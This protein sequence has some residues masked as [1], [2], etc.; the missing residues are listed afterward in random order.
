LIYAFPVINPYV[1]TAPNVVTSEIVPLVVI[2]PP[3]RP[4]PAA[5]EVTLPVPAVVWIV[6]F[7][8]WTPVLI[9]AV[10]IYATLIHIVVICTL[11]WH[12]SDV[13]PRHCQVPDGLPVL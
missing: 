11:P 4:V 8:N 12:T 6:L 7:G 9:S 3:E 13:N 10:A 2:V 1:P 5:T